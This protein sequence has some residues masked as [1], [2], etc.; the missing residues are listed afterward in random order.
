MQLKLFN[1]QEP[2]VL[3]GGFVSRAW[4]EFFSGVFRILRNSEPWPF[5]TFSATG[6]PDPV[7]FE[8]CGIYVR[9]EAGGPTIAFSDG[10]SWRRVTDRNVVS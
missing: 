3:Q 1:V 4:A 10:T 7:N 8:G 5:P 2:L 6:L 9:D